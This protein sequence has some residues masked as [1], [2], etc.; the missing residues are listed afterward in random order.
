MRTRN[1]IRIANKMRPVTG[2]IF[3]MFSC[4]MI[5]LGYL[6]L[7][8]KPNFIQN[9]ISSSMLVLVLISIIW[10]ISALVLLLG[11]YLIIINKKVRYHEYVKRPYTS[12]VGE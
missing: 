3:I 5:I 1:E 9:L 10:F 11:G 7:E 12:N 2:V 8:F 6:A 4:V